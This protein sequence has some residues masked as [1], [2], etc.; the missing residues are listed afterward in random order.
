MMESSERT[1]GD[2]ISKLY[3]LR[4]LP[5]TKI[6]AIDTNWHLGYLKEIFEPLKIFRLG[7]V[8]H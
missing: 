5:L 3:I 7:P 2:Q 6:R 4:L 1:Y 8:S